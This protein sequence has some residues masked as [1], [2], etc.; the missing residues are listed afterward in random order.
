MNSFFASCEQAT[1][2][3]L[4]N[5]P[6]AVAGDPKKRHGIVLAASY[7][8]KKY[9]VKTT[10]PVWQ[11]QKLCKDLII[12]GSH[13][14]DYT[15]YSKKVMEIF[16]RYTPLKEQISIDEAFL[17]MGSEKNILEVAKEIQDVILKELDLP[18]SVG[19]SENKF[20]AKMASEMKKPLGITTLYKSEIK[21][22]LWPLDISKM[23]GVG[24]KSKNKLN[25]MGIVTIGDL[26]NYDKNIIINFFGNKMGR[27]IYNNAKGID[28][29]DLTKTKA[30][31]KSIG[32]EVTL[33]RDTDDIE[34]IKTNVR[35]MADKVGRS[36]RENNYTAKTISVK[37]RYKDFSNA[38]KSMTLKK[39][40]NSNEDI[41][42]AA[43]NLF[44]KF[45]NK[46]EVRLIGVTV[47]NIDT[48]EYKQLNLFEVKPKITD[49]DEMIDKIYKKYGSGKIKKGF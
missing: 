15:E 5:L 43:M 46:N 4:K 48:G 38:A 7:E 31:N 25:N 28:S 1:D 42:N 29:D 21:E 11:A 6:I 33:V 16:D 12:V 47:S 23:Y 14:S 32:K 19:I 26:A 9:G 36:L 18:C 20:L 17:D 45:W 35:W 34:K 39:Y 37:I 10:M 41:Y 40:I 44:L 13:Y 49:E 8:A 27:A 3:K 2:K 30:K 24:S 22:K